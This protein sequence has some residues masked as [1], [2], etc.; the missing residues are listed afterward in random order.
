MIVQRNWFV[1]KEN[2]FPVLIREDKQTIELH[3][4]TSFLA[5]SKAHGID[6][7]SEAL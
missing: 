2:M 4:S 7:C 5:T 6:R 3:A 1:T